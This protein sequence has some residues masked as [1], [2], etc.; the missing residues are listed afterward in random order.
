[1]RVRSRWFIKVR[2][3]ESQ[4]RSSKNHLRKE[5]YGN[6]ILDDRGF[7]HVRVAI[8]QFSIYP[9]NGVIL[10]ANCITFRIAVI[11]HVLIDASQ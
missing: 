11:V 4:K 10:K 2:R 8:S 3:C 1:M 5:A 9:E 6:Y 7:S